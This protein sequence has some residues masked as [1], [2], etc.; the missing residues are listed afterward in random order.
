[1][2][3]LLP[4]VILLLT[5][6][7][8]F[9]L[10]ADEPVSTPLASLAVQGCFGCHGPQGRSA[11]PAI[12]SI[13][14][15]PRDYLFEVLRAYRH[16]GRFGTVMGRLLGDAGDA[17]LDAMADYFSRQTPRVPKQRVDWDL[18]SK[19]RQLHRLYCRECHGDRHRKSEP[20]TP[21]LNGQWM[22]YLRWTL[23]D[24]LLGANQTGEEMSRS[25]IRVIRRHGE[26]GLEALIHYYGSARPEPEAPPSGGKIATSGD[27][28]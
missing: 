2:K 22:G 26:E 7:P 21:R 27:T 9:C 18:A 24:Y 15:L 28:H 5:L 10:S 12:P 13:A 25:L 20:E 6:L 3:P 14:G 19:G 8:S 16:G 4:F 17:E 1:M 11:T 23:R